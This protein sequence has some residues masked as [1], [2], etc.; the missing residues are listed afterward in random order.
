M[1]SRI[2]ILF[3]VVLL[4]G[5]CKN[6]N[7]L[8]IPLSD[9]AKSWIPAN[10]DSL[11]FTDALELDT[12]YLSYNMY[13]RENLSIANDTRGER[14]TQAGFSSD[15]GFTIDYYLQG[16][17][18]TTDSLGK[19]LKTDFLEISTPTSFSELRISNT[20]ISGTMFYLD[21]L[22]FPDSTIVYNVFTDSSQF[23]MTRNNA[24]IQFKS[25]S[26]W[27]YKK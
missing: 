16:G 4:F 3:F 26:T 23:F 1:T 6:E 27:Y 22:I 2:L 5:A 24:V 21:S 20:T 8:Y 12:V 11:I 10:Q 7:S 19:P 15:T 9:Y 18:P 14:I 17:I 13:A 25:G